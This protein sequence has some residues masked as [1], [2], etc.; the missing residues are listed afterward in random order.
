ME[1]SD[2]LNLFGLDLGQFV[3]QIKLGVSQVLWG[4]EVGLK[5]RFF[6]EVRLLS[7][8]NTP[9]SPPVADRTSSPFLALELQGELA[10]VR[11]LTLPAEAEVF[12]SDAVAAEALSNTPFAL[13]ETVYGYRIAHRDKEHVTVH[14]ALMSRAHAEAALDS[15]PGLPAERRAEVEIWLRDGDAHIIIEGFG[16]RLR[17][18]R[19]L[20][21]LR[22][23]GSRGGAAIL[24]LLMI[25]SVPSVWLSQ[26]AAQMMQMRS[27]TEARTRG[28]VAVRDD[29]MVRQDKLDRASA[30]FDDYP[31]YRPWI[32]TLSAMTPDSVFL[33]RLGL[34]QAELTI[35]GLA[36]NAANYQTQLATSGRFDKL[37]AP[38]AFTRDTRA[39]RERFTL[40]MT[41]PE[42]RP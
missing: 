4:D 16:E 33:N 37:N 11:K 28:V 10:L 13:E 15:C 19:Y 31:D 12:L 34:K 6:P 39:K 5:A 9:Q 30:F 27:E 23:V 32:H 2:Q 24:A 8:A 21:I 25:L 1:K 3:A 35:S 38:S 7:S 42:A 22:E 29:L 14:I 26:S 40:V 18:D 17:R 36:E 20:K 41:L